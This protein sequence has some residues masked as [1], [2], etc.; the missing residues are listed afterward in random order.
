MSHEEADRRGTVYDRDDNSYLFNLKCAG[1][2]AVLRAWCGGRSERGA[3]PAAAECP[4]A[5]LGRSS[6]PLGL[7]AP[8][9]LVRRCPAPRR[10]RSLEWVIDA[11]QKGNTLRFANHSTSANCRAE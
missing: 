3:C 11:R 1:R 4:A 10:A 2:G 5:G 7:Q 9:C 8:P 6:L